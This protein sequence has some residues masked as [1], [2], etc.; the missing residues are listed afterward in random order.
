MTATEPYWT[1]ATCQ[2]STRWVE[3]TSRSTN[4]T[5]RLTWARDP[6]RAPRFLA[7]LAEAP[8]DLL[9]GTASY[10]HRQNATVLKRLQRGHQCVYVDLVDRSIGVVTVTDVVRDGASTVFASEP[11]LRRNPWLKWNSGMKNHMRRCPQTYIELSCRS[12]HREALDAPDTARRPNIE[13]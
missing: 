6:H 12:V 8:A 9:G 2:A 5:V 7:M 13:P 3:G 11:V 1:P 4:R 10:W